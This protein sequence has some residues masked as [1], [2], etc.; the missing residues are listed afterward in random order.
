MNPDPNSLAKLK[1]YLN[2]LNLYLPNFSGS[3]LFTILVPRCGSLGNLENA[4]IIISY[5]VVNFVPTG[6]VIKAFT[7]FG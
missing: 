3:F 4:S 5:K 1:H 2:V 7:Y 6:F